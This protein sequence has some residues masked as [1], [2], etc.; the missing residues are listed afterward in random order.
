MQHTRS[1]SAALILV[2]LSACSQ[3]SARGEKEAHRDSEV[4]AHETRRLWESL[5]QHTF[6]EKAAFIEKAEA[7]LDR[8]ERGVAEFRSAAS[9][10]FATDPG[11]AQVSEDLRVRGEAV[12]GSLADVRASTPETWED[13]KSRFFVSI[14]ELRKTVEGALAK[15]D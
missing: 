7:A 9:D 5:S 6:A 15:L 13:V 4:V 11:W 1:A 3:P 2:A 14:A 12:R 8:I 10:T